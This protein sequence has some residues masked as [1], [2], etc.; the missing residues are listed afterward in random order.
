MSLSVRPLSTGQVRIKET[1]HRGVG[2]GLARRARIMR[3][4]PMTGPLPIHAWVIEHPE[5][6]ILVDT[7]ESHSARNQAFATFAVARED[8]LD[9]QLRAAGFAPSDVATVVLTHIHGD[10][11]DGLPHVPDARVLANAGEIAVARSLA[12]RI[13]R[14]VA[15]QPLPPGFHVEP[16]ALDGA[17][18]GAF[19]A[20]QA[21]TADGRIVAVPAP[22]HTP[23]HMAIIVVQDDHH[24]LIGGDSAYDQAQ[25][26]D[27]QVDGVSPDDEVARATMQTILDHARRHP[28]VYLPSHDP[29]SAARLQATDTLVP[30]PA[31]ASA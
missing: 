6:L 12:G 1:M 25:L 21:L 11:V 13:T 14:T 3:P 8:E 9:H 22:G 20:S 15:R 18:F 2:T 30:A 17:P 29:Q 19:A 27:L 28:T 23:G 16:V 24:V 5:G 31:A 26:L 4:G 10:H 7:G